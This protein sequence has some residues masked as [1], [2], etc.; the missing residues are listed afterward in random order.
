MAG[1]GGTEPGLSLLPV[2][3]D[4]AGRKPEARVKRPSRLDCMRLRLCVCVCVCL[5]EYLMKNER[6]N[7]ITNDMTVIN[8]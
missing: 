5:F 2:Q 8:Q 1:E 7:F 3:D 6:A 4:L